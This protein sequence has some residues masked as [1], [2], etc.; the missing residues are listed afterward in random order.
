MKKN[1]LKS[2]ILSV[3]MLAFQLNSKAQLKLIHYWDFNKTVPCSG[4]G[5]IN[6]S[7][8]AADYSTLGHAMIVNTQVLTPLR[9][10]ILDNENVGTTLNQRYVSALG[11]DTTTCGINLNVRARNPMTENQFL[12]YLPTTNYKNILVSYASSSSGSG[13][14]ENI[15]SYSLDSGLTF[16]K[17]GLGVTGLP[18]SNV[19]TPST[20]TLFQ[21]NFSSIS[22]VNNNPKFVLKISTSTNNA[23]AHGNDRYDNITVEGDTSIASGI[24]EINA[25]NSEYILYPNP[26][27][28]NLFISGSYEGN[29]IIAISNIIGEVV[30][31]TIQ[32]KKEVMINTS[33]LENGVYFVTIKEQDGN[34]PVT[35]KFIKS[36]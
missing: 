8:L 27:K 16:I 21:L 15:Y 32:N 30:F 12:I 3:A 28:D 31:A 22:A 5:G 34:T 17:T 2:V 13:P 35:L 14:P 26:S 36:N 25:K 33:Q 1:L 4:A 23:Y 6:L 11:Y 9:D 24:S 20:W 7:P 29:K 18:D 19:V 10:S